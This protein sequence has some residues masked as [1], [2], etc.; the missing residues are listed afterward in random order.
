M[1]SLETLN[2][3]LD[4]T[5]LPRLGCTIGESK[6]Y[7]KYSWDGIR[8]Q[9]ELQLGYPAPIEEHQAIER[10]LKSLLLEAGFQEGTIQIE[11][12][13]QPHKV[14]KDLKPKQGI[15]NIIAVGSGKGGVGKSTVAANL[16]ISLAQL[17]ARVG[18]LDADIHGPSQPKM[19]GEQQRAIIS[20]DKKI[21]PLMRHGLYAV[22]IGYLI[23]DEAP[24][25]WRGP[26]VSGAL[27]Q[28]LNDTEWPPLDYLIIDLPPGTGDI[29]LTLAQKIPLAG[30]VMVTT[31]QDVA[32]LDVAK[33]VK[34]FHKVGVNVLGVIENM[35]FY[36]CSQCGH[37]ESIFGKGGGERLAR[38]FQLP[39]LGA[40][41]L[42]PPLCE[43]A[44]LGVP[45]VAKFPEH[46]MA[47]SFKEA[48]LNM[49]SSLALRTIDYT[50]KL[51]PI[52]LERSS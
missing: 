10:S 30:A 20:A 7:N 46:P 4:R 40:L 35:S 27:L 38:E 22:S 21:M 14:Q 42:Y 3:L 48:A 16:A 33:G 12:I 8:Y 23:D 41:P 6:F 25:V 45:W 11:N 15:A 9:V 47:L 19:L 13:I 28:L 51:P 32:L 43:E 2:I 24:T 26:M 50:A 31:P 18:L 5:F 17:G 29:Q 39:L 34:M 36:H 52:I 37:L 44:D 1:T 49:V